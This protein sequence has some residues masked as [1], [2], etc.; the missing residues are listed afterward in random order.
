MAKKISRS[1]RILRRKL[2]WRWGGEL[3]HFERNGR[4]TKGGRNNGLSQIN[5]IKKGN[6]QRQMASE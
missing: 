2:Y 6:Y 3:D 4:V 5:N 1:F